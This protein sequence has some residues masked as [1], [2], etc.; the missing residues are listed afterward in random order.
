[1]HVKF[2]KSLLLTTILSLCALPAW[3]EKV[4]M[5]TGGT[6]SVVG[7]L[8]RP[9]HHTGPRGVLMLNWPWTRP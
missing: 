7:L 3:A 9:W 8:P 4:S 6:N 5:E 2:V 1:M